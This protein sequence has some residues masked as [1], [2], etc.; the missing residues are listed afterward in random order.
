[1]E[2]KKITINVFEANGIEEVQQADCALLSRA[3]QASSD[4]YAPFSRFNVGAAVRLSDGTVV[5]GSNQENAAYPSGLCA[6]R[7]ALFYA[8]SQY[9]HLAVEALAVV[10]VSEGRQTEL[11]A[12]PCGACRQ[13]MLECQKR[14]GKP[15]R[16]IMGG[17]Q[18]IQIVENVIDLLPL[19]FDQFQE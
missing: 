2:C 5:T 11:P 3:H 19:A 7:T 14:G 16:V 10:A 9:P 4:A 15:L 8:Q 1:M 17:S 6:E 12:Y 13:V 18:K